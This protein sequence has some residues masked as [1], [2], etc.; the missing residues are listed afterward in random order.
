MPSE[1]MASLEVSNLSVRYG[2]VPALHE[3]SVRIGRGQV[4]TII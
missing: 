2:K 1:I 4:V 3:V